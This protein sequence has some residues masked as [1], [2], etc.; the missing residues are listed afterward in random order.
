MEGNIAQPAAGEVVACPFDR[1]A[2]RIAAVELGARERF[3]QGEQGDAAAAAH[4]RPGGGFQPLGD[5]GLRRPLTWADTATSPVCPG[6]RSCRDEENAASNPVSLDL[7][8]GALA[9]GLSAARAGPGRRAHVRYASAGRKVTAIGPERRAL[10]GSAP[11]AS[12]VLRIRAS[13]APLALESLPT[14]RAW[15]RGPG[16]RPGPERARRTSADRHYREGGNPSRPTS[17][18]G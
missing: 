16:R 14:Q 6:A 15:R 9:L 12:T 8:K 10:S 3:G 1:V 13:G 2:G 7:I 4:V 17:G 18:P 11:P 5:V